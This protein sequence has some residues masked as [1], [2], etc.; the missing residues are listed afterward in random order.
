M[1][2]VVTLCLQLAQPASQQLPSLHTQR[3]THVRADPDYYL[4]ANMPGILGEC[5]TRKAIALAVRCAA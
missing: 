4:L 5:N 2:H 3:W 1:F